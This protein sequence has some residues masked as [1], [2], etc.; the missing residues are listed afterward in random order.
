MRYLIGPVILITILLFYSLL[1]FY[2]KY[3]RI[4]HDDILLP[5]DKKE[6]LYRFLWSLGC[7]VIAGVLFGLV[8]VVPYDKKL[9]ID[10][11]FWWTIVVFSGISFIIFCIISFY[12]AKIV[13]DKVDPIYISKEEVEDF[14]IEEYLSYDLRK[15]FI[16]RKSSKNYTRELNMEDF[17]REKL[18]FVFWNKNIYYSKLVKATIE[19]ALSDLQNINREFVNLDQKV[20]VIYG[21]LFVSKYLRPKFNFANDLFINKFLE[22]YKK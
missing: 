2:K 21:I 4:F 19:F 20:R 17:I 18:V 6:S 5:Y 1:Y 13:L 11:Y 10:M 22:M 7:L 9:N 12:F 15:A 8:F 16:T 3:I 14:V